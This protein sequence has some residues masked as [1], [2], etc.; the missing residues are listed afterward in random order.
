MTEKQILLVVAI[1]VLVVIVG[2]VW[3]YWYFY[4]REHLHCPKCGYNW[5]PPVLKMVFSV[6]AVDGKVIRCPAC[7]RREFMR[8]EQDVKKS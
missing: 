2:A 4:R 6:N 3:R 1:L 8:I 7:S 5:K